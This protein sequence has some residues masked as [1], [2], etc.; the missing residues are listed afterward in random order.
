MSLNSQI[1]KISPLGIGLLGLGTVGSGVSKILAQ[2]K[3]HLEEV[4]GRPLRLRGILVRDTGK[5]REH[6][7]PKNLMTDQAEEILA[8]P[9]I[10]IIVEV[11]GGQKFA[12]D[13]IMKSIS[14]GKHVVTANKEV[15]ARF[16]TDIMDAAHRNGVK[17][18]FEASVCAG[19]PI[20]SPLSND[21]V[22]NDI[23]KIHGII[24]GTTNYILTR[25]S[26]DNMSFDEALSDAQRLGF[27]ESDPTNDIEGIDAAYKLAILS[28]LAFK[29]RVMDSDIYREGISDLSYN[30]FLYAEDLGYRIKLLSIATK[31][32][33]RLQMRVHPALVPAKTMIANV[34]GVLN[35]VEIQADLAGR[36]L[37]HGQGAGSLTTTSA[38]I[39][40]I[41]AI[42]RSS[43]DGNHGVKFKPTADVNID[44]I[45]SLNTKYYLR[46]IVNDMPGVLAQITRILGKLKISIASIIQKAVYQTNHSA[47]IVIMTHE[48]NEQSMQ[49]ALRLISDLETVHRI[50]SM[51]RVED[52]STNNS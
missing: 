49:K 30:D 51:I 23:S 48:S 32:N 21:L 5:K 19:T 10:D 44:D 8:N 27:A 3:D 46:L 22:T 41:V 42:A 7:P 47:E 31:N 38:V 18:M 15:M 4:A 39:S 13:Y 20:I 16:G 40:D 6:L 12:F 14:R 25:M 35:A 11:M 9:E 17:V 26:Q 45:H 37:F 1:P 52:L 28:T 36:I 33:S 34:N 24:N 2:K 29:T 50:G 43:S